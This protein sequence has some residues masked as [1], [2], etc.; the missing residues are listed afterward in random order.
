MGTPTHPPCCSLLFCLAAGELREGD[1]VQVFLE[2]AG[3]PEGDFLVS[4]VQVRKGGL[5][6]QVVVVWLG[7]RRC[8]AGQVA[9]VW[10][11]LAAQRGGR[12]GRLA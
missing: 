10:L 2:S 5:S 11:G 7:R 6:W 1:V 8:M 4:G 12:L 3:T 9:V